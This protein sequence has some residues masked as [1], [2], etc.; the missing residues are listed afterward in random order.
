MAYVDSPTRRRDKAA[1]KPQRIA[2]VRNAATNTSTMAAAASVSPD[3]PLTDKQKAFVKAIAEGNPIP[4]AMQVAGYNEQIS[5]G[6]RMMKM[7]NIKRALAVYQAE[8][9][10][11]AELSRKDVM[12]MLK[13]AYDMA[14][15]MSEPSSMV[16][17]AREIGK[18]CGYYEPHKVQVDINMTGAVKFGQLSDAELFAMIEKAAREAEAAEISLL[19]SS[20]NDDAS[21]DTDTE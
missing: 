12:N 19:E 10:A 11:A 5:Y 21:A 15:L 14:K 9:A 1:E 18:M 4:T 6:Y 3:K 2:A 13:E 17:A 7:P 8:Y 16:S 20:D